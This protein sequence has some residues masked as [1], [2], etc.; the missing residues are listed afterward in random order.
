[1][2]HSRVPGR[3]LDSLP[4][5]PPPPAHSQQIAR[6]GCTRAPEL[7]KPRR[8]GDAELTHCP[9]SGHTMHVNGKVALVTGAAQGI[10]RAIAEALL[11]KGAKVRA[12]PCRRNLSAHPQTRSA[13]P[14]TSRGA[15]GETG[16]LHLKCPL[17]HFEKLLRP[18]VSSRPRKRLGEKPNFRCRMSGPKEER[19]AVYLLCVCFTSCAVPG[20]LSSVCR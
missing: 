10:G 6:R 2:T 5:A 16:R 18:M 1:M 13:L 8:R 17:C 20:L 11:H 12:A 9:G 7:L 14:T 19:L 4:P 15:P 3:W